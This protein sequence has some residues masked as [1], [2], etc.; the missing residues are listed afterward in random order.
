ML[1]N[2]IAEHQAHITPLCT[3]T[4]S[5]HC[6]K[7]MFLIQVSNIQVHVVDLAAISGHLGPPLAVQVSSAFQR[8]PILSGLNYWP[9]S[10]P[11]EL[12]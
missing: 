12:G 5:L 2:L 3:Q 11:P 10:S 8:P 7:F 1:T 6:Y 4:P 9:S